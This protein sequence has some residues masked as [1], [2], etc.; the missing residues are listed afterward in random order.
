MLLEKNPSSHVL[1]EALA[2]HPFT[3]VC[4]SQFLHESALACVHFSKMFLHV[5]APAKQHPT[6]L[7]FQK[8]L[9][10]LL[11]P[12]PFI[13]LFFKVKI[14]GSSGWLENHCVDMASSKKKDFVLLM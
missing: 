3:C 7:T 5:F 14:L 4:F 9:K 2:E 10:S 8:I 13:Y 12:P 1:S 6:Q 11:H